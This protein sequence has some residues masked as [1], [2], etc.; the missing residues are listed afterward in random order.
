MV[1]IIKFEPV[2]ELT[3]TYGSI[4]ASSNVETRV[5][6]YQSFISPQFGFMGESVRVSNDN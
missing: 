2:S 6:V 4:Q 5:H 3:Q 1:I